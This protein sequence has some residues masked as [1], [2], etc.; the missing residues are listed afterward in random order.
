MIGL[1]G[2]SFDPVHLG[3]V[4]T[5]EELRARF[6]FREIRFLPAARS[7]LKDSVTADVHRVAMLE[8][9]LAGHPGLVLDRSE[10]D[11]PPPSYTID[12]LHQMRA[13]LGPEEPLVFILGLDSCLELP[14]WRE[15]QSLTDFA[16]LLVV[17]RPGSAWPAGLA[18]A[19]SLGLPAPA[20]G[21]ASP[22]GT[23]DEPQ[24]AAGHS[25]AAPELTLRAWLSPRLTR[26]PAAL[27]GTP[28]G[29]VL[30]AGTP[31]F[32]IASRH[33]RAAVRAGQDTSRW[34]AP[35]VRDYID[36]HHIYRGDA[37]PQ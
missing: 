30:L 16:H 27:S 2:G 3:H 34:L 14:R 17:S 1:F 15:W 25:L 24:A 6:G 22:P 33:I 10:L 31:P 26:D 32:E 9:A 19:D 23:P 4:A 12:T 37:D 29:H 8:R 20:D 11:R 7:P 35:A 5:A 28:A 13:S 36:Q 18:P 21:D